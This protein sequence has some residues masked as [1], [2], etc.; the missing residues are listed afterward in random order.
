MDRLYNNEAL[1]GCVILRI[2]KN[3]PMD[4]TRLAIIVTILMTDK[5]RTR[6]IKMRQT[7]MPNTISLSCSDLITNRIYQE[8]LVVTINSLVILSQSDL[9]LIRKDSIALMPKGD[10][11]NADLQ[12]IK[13]KRFT[14]I[15]KKVPIMLNRLDGISTAQLYKSLNIQL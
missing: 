7:S 15:L 1:V 11:I 12:T 14:D 4:I 2:L 13:S 3:G 8:M 6:L 9:V 10:S 5:I